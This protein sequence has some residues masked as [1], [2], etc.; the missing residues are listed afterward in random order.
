MASAGGRPPCICLRRWGYAFYGQSESN[1]TLRLLDLRWEQLTSWERTRFGDLCVDCP[2]WKPSSNNFS[3]VDENWRASNTRFLASFHARGNALVII[4]I[5]DFLFMYLAFCFLSIITT[6]KSMHICSGRRCISFFLFKKESPLHT[7]FC[8]NYFIPG[9]WHLSYLHTFLAIFLRSESF[10]YH[11]LESS[12]Y[13][14][15]LS[16]ILWGN[17]ICLHLSASRFCHSPAWQEA[18]MFFLA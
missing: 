13:L 15:V 5:R 9:K 11:I 4:F 6:M 18:V 3:G 2:S 12:T 16:L 7:S 17:P 14:V 8:N 10:I 1:Q